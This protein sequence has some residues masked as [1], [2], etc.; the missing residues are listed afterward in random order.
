MELAVRHP[1]HVGGLVLVGPTMDPAARTASRQILRW[2]SDT[3]RED[4]LQLPILLRDIHDA[5]PRRVVGTLGHA[6]RDPIEDKL[7]QVKVPVLVTRGSRRD[8]VFRT[9]PQL[10]VELVHAARA[11]GIRFRA[12]VADCF[13]GDNPGFTHA[14]GTAKVPFVLARK[15]RW[16][17]WAPADAAHTPTEA[18]AELG[19]HGPS[20]PGQ[21]RRIQRR[22]RD[23]H[24]ETW[25]AADAALGGWVP[26]AGCGWW[27]PPPTPLGCR[28][29]AAGSCSPTSPDPPAAAPS[30][31]TWLRWCACMG[32]ATGSSRATSRS[33]V[34]WAGLT[35]RSARIGRSAATGHWCVV[36]SASA[37]RPSSLRTPPNRHRLTC[38]PPPR[39]PR[40]GPSRP[41]VHAEPAKS[42][43]PA[44]LRAVRAWLTPW[45]V[46]W[47]CWQ[48]WSPAP[49]PRQLQ[50]LLDGLAAGRPLHF[51]LPP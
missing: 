45:S 28:A 42:S 7:P 25:W 46:L 24:T 29:T 13:Y 1:D 26:T 27:W 14:L 39:R 32:C 3:V 48:S 10:A 33:R 30:R 49:P 47:R 17:T 12:V 38:R 4:P 23:G 41:D 31:P 22:F 9:K 35:S 21:W 8:P 18:A 20:R 2:L 50:G 6:L 15:P 34:S 36:R 16:G 51:Y 11:A 43:W 40:G 19:W 5:G 37:G 44:A